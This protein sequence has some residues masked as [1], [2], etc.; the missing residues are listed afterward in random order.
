[1]KLLLVIVLFFS[2]S[3]K[4]VTEKAQPS[5]KLGALRIAY[6]EKMS[7]VKFDKET[8]WPSVKDCDAL[9]WAGLARAAGAE[10]RLEL[11]EY[12]SGELHRR[13]RPPCWENGEDKGSKSTISRDM[14]LGWLWAKWRDKDIAALARFQNR[15]EAKNW[16]VG[17]PYPERAGEVLLTGNLIGL[18]GRTTCEVFQNCPI[19][20][21]IEPIHSKSSVDYV[22]HLTVLFI[23][24]NGEVWGKNTV[25]YGVVRSNFPPEISQTDIK[26]S[27]KKILEWHYEQNKNDALFSAAWHL[28]E[29]GNF[30][31]PIDLLLSSVYTYPTY[32]RGDDNYRDVHWLF[33]ARLILRQYN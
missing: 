21:K 1:M 11:A 8:G 20:R 27:E 15:A 16:V 18:L 33:V 10:L 17:Q 32:V 3:A 25:E 23:L 19:Y 2:C 7:N 24:L 13:P 30:D 6:R 26:E 9:L 22:Q 28:Y 12:S 29:D 14:I 5:E 31:E 4:D